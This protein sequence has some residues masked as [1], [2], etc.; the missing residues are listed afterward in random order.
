MTQHHSI[1]QKTNN[2]S[3][4]YQHKAVGKTYKSIKHHF[5]WASEAPLI[6]MSSSNFSQCSY[7]TDEALGKDS[8]WNNH[9]ISAASNQL[10]R[11]PIA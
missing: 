11:L 5:V 1:N 3:L 2:K 4:F 8:S 6:Q 10:L 9:Y 7:L